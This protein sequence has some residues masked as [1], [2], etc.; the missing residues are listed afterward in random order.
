M[1]KNYDESQQQ[2]EK[3]TEILEQGKGLQVQNEQSSLP[4]LVRSGLHSVLQLVKIQN[5][6][7]AEHCVNEDRNLDAAL[8]QKL[9]STEKAIKEI[10][11]ECHQQNLRDKGMNLLSK[12]LISEFYDFENEQNNQDTVKETEIRSIPSFNGDQ[13]NTD[14]LME[15][16]FV[17]INQVGK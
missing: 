11:F 2:V 10:G 7:I 17:Q 9:V 16:M 13:D 8:Q 15:Q 12:E 5:Q 3:L 1:A 4:N 14:V 6:Q